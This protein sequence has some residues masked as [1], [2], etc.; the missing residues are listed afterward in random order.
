METIENRIINIKNAHQT[1]QEH[2]L[3]RQFVCEWWKSFWY[4][5]AL[6]ISNYQIQH[7]VYL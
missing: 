1:Q 4:F 5:L 3:C 6:L 7:I 2:E